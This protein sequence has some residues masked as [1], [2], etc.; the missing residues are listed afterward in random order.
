MD[1]LQL[2]SSIN[3]RITE[4]D[5]KITKTSKSASVAF[6]YLYTKI[7]DF[8]KTDSDL[9]NKINFTNERLTYLS[10][11]TDLVSNN[12][13][14]YFVTLSDNLNSVI[15]CSVDSTF[16][17]LKKEIE[18][19]KTSVNEI[20]EKLV[21][22]DKVPERYIVVKKERTTLGKLLHNIGD[23]FF[24]LFH[25]KKI[26]QERIEQ[27]KLE[28]ERKEKELKLQQ[29]LELQRKAEEEKRNAEAKKKIKELIKK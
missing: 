8:N 11:K 2:V 13:Y 21:D 1:T 22:I 18:D 27:E 28:Q 5:N 6:S 15:T 19:L 10:S 20:K 3:E 25:A 29:E 7:N 14:S 16:N 9:E 23:F 17:D 26:K 12:S 4:L 24:K